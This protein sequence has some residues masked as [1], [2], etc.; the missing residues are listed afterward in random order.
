[1]ASLAIGPGIDYNCWPEKRISGVGPG[2]SSVLGAHPSPGCDYIEEHELYKRGV[3]ATALACLQWG[4]G[5]PPPQPPL[6]TP[7]R[8]KG[9][10]AEYQ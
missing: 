5:Y 7:P 4:L 6:N 3:L 2:F 8:G 1:M 10:P 9:L